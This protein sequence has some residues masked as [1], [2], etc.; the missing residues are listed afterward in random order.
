M[1]TL[2]RLAKRV[3][4]RP[5]DNFVLLCHQ[6]S[7][8]NMLMSAVSRH[9][10]IAYYGQLYKDDPEHRRRMDQVARM[11]YTGAP[12]DDTLD[13]RARFERYEQ[14]RS[15]RS[16]SRN[17][18]AY[19][20]RFFAEAHRRTAARYV[21]IKFHGGTLYHDEIA[22]LFL[23]GEYRVIIQHR[24]NLLAAA[25]SWYQARELNQWRRNDGEPV[26]TPTLTMDIERLHWFIENTRR[27][28]ALWKKLCTEAG[29]PYL[30]QTYE[31]ILIDTSA[32]AGRF[33]QHLGL[34]PLPR[35]EV[36]TKKLIK[37][38]DHILNI[39]VIRRELAGS[40]NG[41]V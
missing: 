3:G 7:G 1:K 26:I 5:A 32:A 2:R 41:E 4:L 36:R 38:Y 35:V 29:Q 17:T 8:S 25:I 14:D 20:R 21:G 28:V 11:V 33:W 31:G 12:F 23:D 39:D 18:I 22:R 16:P 13:Q 37:T 30:E 6:R 34:D 19:T 9:P 10:G 40:E 24:E 27:D 15:G